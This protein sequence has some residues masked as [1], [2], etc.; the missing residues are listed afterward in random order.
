MVVVYEWEGNLAGFS[1]GYI[2]RRQCTCALDSLKFV[3]SLSGKAG[4]LFALLAPIPRE[5]VSQTRINRVDG[6]EM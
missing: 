4:D 3:Y 1:L 6:T 2:S 5:D